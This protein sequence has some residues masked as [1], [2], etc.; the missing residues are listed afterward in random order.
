MMQDSEKCSRNLLRIVFKI[1]PKS[2]YIPHKAQYPLK[3]EATEAIT[4]VYNSLLKVGVTVSCTPIFPV[5]NFKKAGEPEMWRFVQD[6][7]PVNDTVM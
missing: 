3:Q 5:K 4:P 1:T 6:L 2:N 7:K